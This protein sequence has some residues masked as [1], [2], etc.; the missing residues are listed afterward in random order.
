MPSFQSPFKSVSVGILCRAKPVSVSAGRDGDATHRKGSG[1]AVAMLAWAGAI[2]L[3]VGRPNGGPPRRRFPWLREAP[4]SASLLLCVENLPPGLAREAPSLWRS[5]SVA[6]LIIIG[7]YKKTPRLCLRGVL[8]F[9]LFRFG[10][11]RRRWRRW[12][13]LRAFLGSILRTSFRRSMFAALS[14]AAP[15]WS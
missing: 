5:V 15:A 6:M 4:F 14:L 9:K 11:F 7:V 8:A 10:G 13:I 3:P 2:P 12:S 1:M